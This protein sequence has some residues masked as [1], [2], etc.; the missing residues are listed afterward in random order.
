MENTPPILL[1][2]EENIVCILS[3][4]LAEVIRLLGRATQLPHS[5]SEVTGRDLP[6]SAL[7]WEDDST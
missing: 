3:L 2:G 1:F 6:V 4:L 7:L 5:D